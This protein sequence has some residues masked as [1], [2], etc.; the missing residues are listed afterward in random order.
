M[1]TNLVALKEFC[2]CFR[3]NSI[4][5]SNSYSTIK[6]RNGSVSKQRIMDSIKRWSL[7]RP[8]MKLDEA[9]IDQLA[10]NFLTSFQKQ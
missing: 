4:Y 1:K 10:T 2:L 3:N 9:D 8:T 7:H 5:T 6:I